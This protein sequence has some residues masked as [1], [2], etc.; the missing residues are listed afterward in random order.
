MQS[1][2]LMI[3]IGLL[4]S[5][6]TIGVP[7]KVRP[8]PED[9]ILTLKLCPF[10]VL[11]CIMNCILMS[12]LLFNIFCDAILK[13]EHLTDDTNTE[14]DLGIFFVAVFINIAGVFCIYLS[15]FSKYKEINAFSKMFARIKLP[16]MEQK[17]AK[18]LSIK[19]HLVHL[20]KSLVLFRITLG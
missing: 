15:F 3:K 4:F 16:P 1:P 11:K 7:V 19:V 9:N 13:E 8:D 2:L 17:K 20:T 6:F 5:F 10:M 12:P 18:N 14:T